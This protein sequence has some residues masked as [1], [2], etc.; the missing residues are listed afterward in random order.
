MAQINCKKCGRKLTSQKS[1]LIGMGSTC[2]KKEG[3]V[4]DR[5]NKRQKVRSHELQEFMEDK[6]GNNN[7]SNKEI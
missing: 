4:L 5:R 7:I 3:I 6:N 2:A 1:I